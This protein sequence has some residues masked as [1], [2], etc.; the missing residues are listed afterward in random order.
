MKS[1]SALV[2]LLTSLVV[3]VG[4]VRIFSQTGLAYGRATVAAPIFTVNALGTGAIV[5]A[6]MT[7]LG[8]SFAWA[9]DIR[10]FVMAQAAMGLKLAEVTRLE[11]SKL[12]WAILLS[13]AFTLSGSVFAVMQ[14]AYSYGGINLTGWQF[15]GLPEF[16]GN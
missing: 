11:H 9:A 1:P 4:L 2:F 12:F 10:T 8:L 3:F 5:P 15:I 6:G 7:T 14:I 16:S 13:V